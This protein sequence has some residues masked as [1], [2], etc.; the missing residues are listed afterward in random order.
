MRGS[1]SEVGLIIHHEVAMVWDTTVL[2]GIS[3]NGIR[4]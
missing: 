2:E 1:H 3:W 4:S